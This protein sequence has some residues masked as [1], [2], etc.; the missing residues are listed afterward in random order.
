MYYSFE[1]YARKLLTS[2]GKTEREASAML[3]AVLVALN[4][5]HFTNDMARIVCKTD[6]L[7]RL[8]DEIYGA[9]L[10]TPLFT[11]SEKPNSEEL[12]LF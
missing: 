6:D 5:G 3:I 11:V 8:D 7:A 9:L 10:L 2:K 4:D 12:G 1:D